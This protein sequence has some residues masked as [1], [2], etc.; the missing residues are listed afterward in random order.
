VAEPF[1]TDAGLRRNREAI[2]AWLRR[3]TEAN[4]APD[5]PD[6]E[7]VSWFRSLSDDDRERLEADVDRLWSDADDLDGLARGPLG[8]MLARFPGSTALETSAVEQDASDLAAEFRKIAEADPAWSDR[9]EGFLDSLEGPGR[10][11]A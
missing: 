10:P 1:H 3:L 6:V 9:W 7:A 8:K 4:F 2:K 5:D 11:E